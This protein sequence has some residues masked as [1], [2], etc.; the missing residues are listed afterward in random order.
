[1]DVALGLKSGVHGLSGHLFCHRSHYRWFSIV[2][3]NKWH[4]PLEL[5]SLGKPWIS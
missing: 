5:S 3:L 1:M 2:M 4:P